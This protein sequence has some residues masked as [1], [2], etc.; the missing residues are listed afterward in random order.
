M[1]DA[2]LVEAFDTVSGCPAG[3][4][5][6]VESVRMATF[7]TC[8]DA[9]GS[10]VAA[11]STVS[12]AASVPPAGSATVTV[13]PSAPQDR[14]K[15]P[16]GAGALPQLTGAPLTFTAPGLSAGSIGS[17]SVSGPGCGPL[18]VTVSV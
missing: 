9:D 15:S 13:R 3:S 7:C 17:T 1:S 12:G 4:E 6:P 2:P 8:A 10:T 14:V 5:A 18:G 16:A 11:I